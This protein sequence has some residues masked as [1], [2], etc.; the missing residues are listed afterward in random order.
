MKTCARC[1][2]EKPASRD[3]FSFITSRSAFHPWCKPCCAEDR[4]IDRATRPDHYK[5]LDAKRDKDR[6]RELQRARYQADP[7][8]HRAWAAK[9]TPE[10]AAR[11]NENRRR[12]IET[13]PAY[14]EKVRARQRATA[15]KHGHKYNEQRRKAWA[16]A[17]ASKRLRTYF[18]SAICHSLKGTTKGG[19]SW[20]LIL[21]YTTAQLME[22]L[23]RQFERGMSW[24]N[25]GE[26]HVDHILPV[27]SFAFEDA[28]DP[29]FKACWSLTNLRPLWARENLAK[30]DRRT[31]LL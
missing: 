21:G 18:T 29:E 19:R 6:T 9:R 7:E 8:K 5:A 20:E 16:Q 13:D 31:L 25:Y 10:Q 24:T 11:Y 4:R 26:W 27:A 23:E 22:H 17:P 2:A 12:R 3:H 14:A 30:R 15:A 1:K 28:A